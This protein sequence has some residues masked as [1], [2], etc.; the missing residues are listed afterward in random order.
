MDDPTCLFKKSPQTADHL[1]WE[2]EVLRKQTQVLRNS[3]M[4]VGGNWPI[5]NRD[6]ANKYTKCF[7]N[8]VKIINLKNL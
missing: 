3:I 1:L 5:T 6:L 7:Q 4:K 8:F 2:C